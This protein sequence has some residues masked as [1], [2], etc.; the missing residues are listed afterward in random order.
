MAIHR[1]KPIEKVYVKVRS[2]FDRIGD[3]QP[4][5]IIWEDGREFKID[6]VTDFYP[7]NGQINAP[8]DDCYTVKINGEY[9]YL[10]F[11]RTDSYFPSRYGRWYVK[12]A[13]P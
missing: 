11:E 9:K 5:A 8:Q 10:Y 13:R 6:A 4:T 2:F 3:M 7:A 1:E 12:V